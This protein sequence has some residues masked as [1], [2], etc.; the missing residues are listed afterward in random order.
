VARLESAVLPGVYRLV[1]RGRPDASAEYFVADGDRRESD[2]TPLSEAERQTLRGN[3][4]LQMIRT[5]EELA[6]AA[7]HD[8]PR[9]ELWWLLLLGVLALL[10]GEVAMT[11]RL[12]QGGHEPIDWEDSSP[13][14]STSSAPSRGRA[15]TSGAQDGGATATAQ[16]VGAGAR[17]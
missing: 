13:G 16:V 17:K 8:A 7:L 3:G 10:V 14:I 15:E 2:L 1:R 4:R 6:A 9:R 5:P 11:R 12:V